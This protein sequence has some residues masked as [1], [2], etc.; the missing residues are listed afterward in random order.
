MLFFQR[1]IAMT[2]VVVSLLLAITSAECQAGDPEW[3]LL[4]QDGEFFLNARNLPEAEM[5]F[6]DALS[7]KDE[8]DRSRTRTVGLKYA[9]YFP[10][11]ELGIVLFKMRRYEEARIFLDK[12][13][14]S[15]P[16]AR[17]QEFLGKLPPPSAEEEQQ[18]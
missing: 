4:Y 13:M 16:S 10:N 6:R 15:T 18:K 8:G 2:M 17:A 12:S 14:K 9:E 5:C 7:L 11:R 3:Y 1:L